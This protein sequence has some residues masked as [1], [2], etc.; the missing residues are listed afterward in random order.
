LTMTEA[1]ID[2]AA[3]VAACSVSDGVGAVVTFLGLVRGIEEGAPIAALEYES[4]QRMARRQFEVLFDEMTRRWPVESVR[5]AHRVG[6]V[7]VGEASFW[8]EI[9]TPHRE[10]ALAACQWLIGEMKRVVPIWKRPVR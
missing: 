3:L 2:A 5:L 10:E 6:L 7:K 8:V 9:A 4:F 1:P